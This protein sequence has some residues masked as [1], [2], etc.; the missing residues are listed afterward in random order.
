MTTENRRYGPIFTL[1]RCPE[2]DIHY[3]AL[4]D[5]YYPRQIIFFEIGKSMEIPSHVYTDLLVCLL[6]HQLKVIQTQAAQTTTGDW[7]KIDVAT[8]QAA[9]S[10][11]S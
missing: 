9:N 3:A 10:S 7:I 11:Q 5:P 1:T 2:C 4:P 6:G 8:P